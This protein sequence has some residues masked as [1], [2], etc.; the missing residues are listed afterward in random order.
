[1]SSFD[2]PGREKRLPYDF[3]YQGYSTELNKKGP[4]NVN[5]LSYGLRKS[6]TAGLDLLELFQ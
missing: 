2:E 3:D 6:L 4:V 1:M 5:D